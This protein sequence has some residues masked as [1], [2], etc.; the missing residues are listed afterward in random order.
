MTEFIVPAGSVP[1]KADARGGVISVGAVNVQTPNTIELFSSRGPT[2][3]G[4]LAPGHVAPDGVLTSVPGFAPFFGTSAATPHAAGM[5]ALL[6]GKVPSLTPQQVRRA[7][8]DATLDLGQFGP[9]NTYGHGLIDGSVFTRIP[10]LR[11]R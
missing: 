2:N 5:A 9:D 8:Q 7:L 1:N 6:L 10:V 3:D 11:L 4:R